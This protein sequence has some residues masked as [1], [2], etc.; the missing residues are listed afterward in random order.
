MRFT[1]VMLAGVVLC[2]VSGTAQMWYVA[3]HGSDT[4]DGSRLRPFAS[5]QHGYGVAASNEGVQVVWLDPGVYCASSTVYLSSADVLVQ[6]AG[7]D[8]AVIADAVVVAGDAR[9]ADLTCAAAFSNSA[10]CLVHNVKISATPAGAG[11]LYGL[12]Y[13]A[14]DY[15]RV[16]SLAEPRDGFDA[17]SA[18]WVSNHVRHAALIRTGGTMSGALYLEG[19][20]AAPSQAVHKAYVDAAA[21][22]VLSAS[23]AAVA[24]GTGGLAGAYVSKSGDTMTGFLSLPG[25]PTSGVHAVTKSYVDGLMRQPYDA[26]VG[27]NCSSVQAALN[28]GATN[29]FIPPG[30][31]VESWPS[32]FVIQRPV[33]IHGAGVPETKLV[34][35]TSLDYGVF[36]LQQANGL[37]EMSDLELTVTN[38]GSMHGFVYVTSPCTIRLRGI[39]AACASPAGG[40]IW[41]IFNQE[42]YLNSLDVVLEDVEMTLRSAGRVVFYYGLCRQ[43]R[44][45]VRNA[46]VVIDKCGSGQFTDGAFISQSLQDVAGGYIRIAHCAFSVTNHAFDAEHFLQIQGGPGQLDLVHVSACTVNLSVSNEHATALILNAGAAHTVIRDT[47][48]TATRGIRLYDGTHAQSLSN[49]FIEACTFDTG[50]ALDCGG[51]ARAGT[52]I[53]LANCAYN[54]ALTKRAAAR[55]CCWKATGSA[56]RCRPA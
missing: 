3:P 17:V 10:I 44:I 1:R 18:Y 23:Y 13:D 35:S 16:S 20:I 6:G 19:G 27:V 30:T 46:R 39:K 42:S 4:N 28:S 47:R 48:V 2:A 33:R 25:A 26:I 38:S 43:P 29:I 49:V 14:N 11:W 37:F 22:T 5:V 31:Y 9:L 15:A 32:A 54:G 12:W 55:R 45:T 7:V 50:L 53:S 21:A 40:Q 52:V 24:A 34:I 56:V 41:F 51:D 36:K 8:Q